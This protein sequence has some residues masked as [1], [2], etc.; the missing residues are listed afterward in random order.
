MQN[1]GGTGGSVN[2]TNCYATGNVSGRDEVGGLVGYGLAWDRTSVNTTNCYATGNV[3]GDQKIGGLMGYQ[4]VYNATSSNI[5]VNCYAIGNVTVSG[6]NVG[7]IAYQHAYLGGIS[8][9][10]NSYRYINL[11]INGS[12]IPTNDTDSAP[13]KKHGG[14]K[15]MTELLT[16]TTYTSNGWL[17][18]PAGPWFWEGDDIGYPKLKTGTSTPGAIINITA[19]PAANTTVTAGSITGSLTIAATIS[20][21]GTLSYQWYSNTTNSNTGGTAISGATNTSFAIP[22]GLTAGTY[23]YY[24]VVSA[25]GAT[26]VASNVAR[27]TVEE[28]SGCSAIGYGYLALPFLFLLKMKK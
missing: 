7:G 22:I 26:S 18:D 4:Y 9:I 1:T 5:I 10:A 17:F 13:D 24:C 3:S 28:G 2:T 6:D 14:V 11:T 15:T 21:S 19:Q 23:Y 8:I 20:P 27:M 16:K 25:T 12:V